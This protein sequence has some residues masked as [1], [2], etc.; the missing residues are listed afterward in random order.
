MALSRE[1]IL[2][3]EIS[4]IKKKEPSIP[5]RKARISNAKRLYFNDNVK[6]QLR[7]ITQR[8]RKNLH[9]LKLVMGR[10]M[11]CDNII[12][13]MGIT[14]DVGVRDFLT[15]SETF[16]FST[17]IAIIASEFYGVSVEDIMFRDLELRDDVR[18]NEL[19]KKLR[20]DA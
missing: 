14:I 11:T 7:T 12:E 13:H 8:V 1:D 10:Q 19:L 4:E 17:K 2:L 18:P 3:A 15:D 9:H 6:D 20:Y 5:V 16:M